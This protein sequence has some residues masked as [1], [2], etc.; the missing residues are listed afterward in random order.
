MKGGLKTVCLKRRQV[1]EPFEIR[2]DELEI[3]DDYK[4]F[5]WNNSDLTFKINKETFWL[6]NNFKFAVQKSGLPS[7]RDIHSKK[8]GTY[9]VLLSAK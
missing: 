3:P 2:E 4:C 8:F 6:L 9:Y 7:V 1:D 5:D